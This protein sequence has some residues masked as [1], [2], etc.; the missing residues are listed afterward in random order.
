MVFSSLQYFTITFLIIIIITIIR[1]IYIIDVVIII[2][3]IIINNVVISSSSSSSLNS[4]LI[5]FFIS[6]QNILTDWK[7][8]HLFGNVTYSSPL[9]CVVIDVPGI[10]LVY[11]QILYRAD[12]T[13]TKHETLINS[14]KV[15]TRPIER[16]SGDTNGY[17]SSYQSAAFPLQRHDRVCVGT[18]NSQVVLS[19][20]SYFGVALLSRT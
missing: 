10:Y 1:S 18:R 20:G 16:H 12:G 13:F 19:K 17:R 14:K 7:V 9:G 15:L 3:S 6:D 11:N 5:S 8:T 4:D 2:I